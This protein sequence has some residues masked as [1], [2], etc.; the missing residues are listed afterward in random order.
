[1]SQKEGA[2]WGL[3][4]AFAVATGRI[5]NTARDCPANGNLWPI[6]DRSGA[7]STFW[8]MIPDKVCQENRPGIPLLETL[9]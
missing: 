7:K 9:C 4:F 6:R 8:M 2:N 3:K 1:V 5:V